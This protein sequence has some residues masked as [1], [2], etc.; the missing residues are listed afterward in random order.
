MDIKKIVSTFIRIVLGCVFISSAILKL[1]SLDNFILY[2]YSFGLFGYLAT[3]ILTRIL[4]VLE[5]LLGI[6]L[7][8]RIFYKTTW[9]VT[10][11]TL[12]G[13]SIFLLY[14]AF[15]R[16]DENCHCFGDFIELDAVASIIKNIILIALLFCIR[17]QEEFSGK[18]KPY[19][20]TISIAAILFVCFIGFPLD[21]LYSKLYGD[22]HERFNQIAFNK[23]VGDSIPIIDSSQNQIIGL[24][25]AS[26]THCKAGNRVMQ[27]IFNQNNLD[28]SKFKNIVWAGSDSSLNAFKDT[29]KTKDYFYHR[30]SPRYLIEIN[31]GFFPTYVF[32]EKGKATKAI[33]Y[34]E[35]NEKE[36]VDFLSNN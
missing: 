11:V 27:A 3:T 31:Y 6:G 13:F 20:V 18:I 7:L 23:Y 35:I 28:K 29:T 14:A 10:L 1:L 25:S 12:S 26:C 30:M 17:K 36:V 2:V 34:K 9:W 22:D 8:F 21:S 4:I 15:F 5:F 32:F 19:I 33:N 24:V 16:I